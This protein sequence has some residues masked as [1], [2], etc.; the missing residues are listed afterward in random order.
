LR[1]NTN[2]SGTVV[3]RHRAA[4]TYPHRLLRIV[5]GTY[6]LGLLAVLVLVAVVLAFLLPPLS[7]RRATTRALARLWLALAGLRLRVSG[8][9]RLPAGS[10]VLVANHGSYLDGIV[11]KAAL[12]PRF[13]FVVKREASSMP[14]LGLLLRR[15]GSEFVD[16]HH[17]GGRQRDA[18]RVVERA[19]QGHSLV[20]FPEGT[21]D[22]VRG[23]KRFHLGAFVAAARGGAPLLPTVI[24]GA[25]RALPSGSF[26]PKPGA[27][28]VEVLAPIGGHGEPPE[29]LRDQARAAILARLDEPDLT[30]LVTAAA[31]EPR[32]TAVPVD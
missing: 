29:R 20:F 3:R 13:S 9:A 16:R 14:V 5:Y 32:R 4:R 18:R 15:I 12:P 22:S 21:F 1:T 2:D 19:E 10:C 31:R 7:W 26:V 30:A 8:L 24:R 6:A 11:M 25:R 27:I 17:P 23:V 28:E